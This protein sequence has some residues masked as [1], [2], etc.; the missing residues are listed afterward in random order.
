M[1]TTKINDQ[2]REQMYEWAMEGVPLREIVK[3]LDGK[4]TYQRVQ[5]LCRKNGIRPKTVRDVQKM[6]E[7]RETLLKYV[8]KFFRGEKIIVDK[9][10]LELALEKYH[11][12]KSTNPDFQVAFEDIEWR[13]HCPVFGTLLDYSRGASKGFNKDNAASFDRVDNNKGYVKGNVTLVSYRANRIKND[14]SAEDHRLISNY[15]FERNVK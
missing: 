15:M 12:K 10:T 7:D 2:E 14:G 4:I 1:H 6:K 8:S 3:R 9:E 11:Q 13:T 5:Q